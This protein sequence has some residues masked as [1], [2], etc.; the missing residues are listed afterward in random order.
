MAERPTI[1]DIA[2]M[3]GV[4]KA[5]VSRVLNHKP[6]VDPETRERVLRIVAEQGFV[7]SAAAS[8][9]A[10]RSRMLGVLVPSLTWPFIPEIMRGIAEVIEQTNYELVLYSL[11]HPKDRASLLDRILETKLTSGLLAIIPGPAAEHVAALS[12]QGYPVVL[13]D[14][15]TEPKL[16]RWVGVDNVSGGYLAT[17]HLLDLGHRR[18]GYIQGPTHYLCSQERYA[19][20]CQ[21]LREAAI[22]PDPSLVWQGDFEAP[23]GRVCAEQILA[24]P[25]GARP[26]AVFASNDHMAYGMLTVAEERGIAVPEDIAV[27]G[28]DDVPPFIHTRVALT[29]IRQPFYEMGQRSI[30]LLIDLVNAPRHLTPNAQAPATET[31]TRVQLATSVVVRES[32]GARLRGAV[33]VRAS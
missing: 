1:Q 9:L 23:S 22:E 20:Y 5:T 16:A 14:D 15:Q 30:Q 13:I 24:L 19:G 29:T 18:I 12:R 25:D 10:G 21:A 2:R 32:C 4:S 33:T 3:A 6:D 26:T 31:V 28:F 17:R 8:V 7:P 27:I 11:S